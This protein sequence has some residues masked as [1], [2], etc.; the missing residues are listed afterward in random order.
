MNGVDNNRIMRNRLATIRNWLA[1]PPM[2][3]DRE[4][5]EY[6]KK[7]AEEI[8][9]HSE[10]LLECLDEDPVTKEDE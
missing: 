6:M 4:T 9:M 2:D 5:L 1:R 7:A 3:V 10:T 8:V